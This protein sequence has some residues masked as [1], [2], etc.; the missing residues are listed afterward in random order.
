MFSNSRFLRMGSLSTLSSVA[1]RFTS[2]EQFT[3]YETFLKAQEAGLGAEAYGALN[4]AM[5]NA[6]K[7]LDWDNKYMKAF[8]E[9]LEK[10]KNSAPV[11][12]ISIMISMISIAVL[13]IFN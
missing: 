2:A 6:K 4:T 1:G 11:K 7:N 8:N 10:L 13:Y 9:H 3:A 5:I 12:V